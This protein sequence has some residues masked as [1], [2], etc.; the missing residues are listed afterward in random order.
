MN[1][2]P[3]LFFDG[4]CEEAIEFYKKAV[5]AK[6]E[7]LMRNSDSPDKSHMPPGADNKIL[8]AALQVGDS[9]ILASDGHNTG[10]PVFQG[11]RLAITTDDV[12]RTQQFFKALS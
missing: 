9:R 4:R 1:I 7:M 5:G 8:H 3:Y 12:A 2:Q 6:V 10:K 11:F